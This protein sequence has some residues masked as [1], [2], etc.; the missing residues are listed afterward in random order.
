[1]DDSLIL[2][3]A[4]FGWPHQALPRS[5]VTSG[6]P[7]LEEIDQ[8]LTDLIL[9]ANR[10]DAELYRF[11]VKLFEERRRE[12]LKRLVLPGLAAREGSPEPARNP[13]DP[14]LSTR[15]PAPAVTG[16]RPKRPASSGVRI[17]SAVVA[18]RDSGRT[19]V[20][21]GERCEVRVVLLANVRSIEVAVVL[22]LFNSFGTLVYATRTSRDGTYFDLEAG[23]ATQVVFDIPL[24]V[25]L[26]SYYVDL[27][28]CSSSGP[29]LRLMDYVHKACSVD[30]S[31]F[32]GLPFAG[33]ADLAANVY[34]VETEHGGLEYDVG[35]EIDFTS[36]GNSQLYTRTGWAAP[37]EG[38]RWTDGREAELL[39]RLSSAC[40][41]DLLFTAL[42][43]PYCPDRSLDVK[44]VVNGREL[45]RWE[46]LANGVSS[47][48]KMHVP[49]DTAAQGYL[50]IVFQI[51]RPCVPATLGPSQD[52]RALGLAFQRV[53]ICEAAGLPLARQSPAR[54]DQM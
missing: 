4:T 29:S 21:S 23:D 3:S 45:G 46:F 7:S 33:V 2:M 20:K 37:E 26:G 54:A 25:S 41:G 11:G 14:P 51:D 8:E 42:V 30:V 40:R 44:A 9:Q 12:M 50:H 49:A 32:T 13:A 18:G 28:V 5:N 16:A 22:R 17:L 36:R 38:H 35:R 6:R 34:T 53:V 48:L 47:G 27:E 43:M 19:V 15:G 10:L 24:T 52:N 39:C 1:M 31:G